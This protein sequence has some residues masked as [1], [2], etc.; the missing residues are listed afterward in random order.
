MIRDLNQFEFEFEFE[1][2]ELNGLKF[3]L[4][5]KLLRKLLVHS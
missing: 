2:I 4:T 5:I 3:G 1:L